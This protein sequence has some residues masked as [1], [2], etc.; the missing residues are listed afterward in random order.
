M[1]DN[2]KRDANSLARDIEKE[3]KKGERKTKNFLSDIPEDYKV[4]CSAVPHFACRFSRGL[5]RSY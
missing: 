4:R 1:A 5:P 3:S 2:I